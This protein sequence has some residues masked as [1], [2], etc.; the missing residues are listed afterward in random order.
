M[1]RFNNIGNSN[2]KLIK[3]H[4]SILLALLCFIFFH[5]SREILSNTKFAIHEDLRRKTYLKYHFTTSHLPQKNKNK[6]RIQKPSL[7]ELLSHYCWASF[8]IF[9]RQI[10]HYSLRCVTNR[11]IEKEDIEFF[12]TSRIKK[13]IL[14]RKLV[15]FLSKLFKK[16]W[17]QTNVIARNRWQLES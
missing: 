14:K 16:M 17:S 11:E 10:S 12:I 7:F 1:K 5:K 15:Y 8:F 6:K 9:C 2:K 4:L 3:L 13:E